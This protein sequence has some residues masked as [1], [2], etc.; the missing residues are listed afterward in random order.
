M[1]FIICNDVNEKTVFGPMAGRNAI[2][3][4]QLDVRYG[5]LAIMAMVLPIRRIIHF[6]HAWRLLYG[7]WHGW[8]MSGHWVDLARVMTVIEMAAP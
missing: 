7:V 3:P 8:G 6:C 4:R 1:V 5:R 2:V